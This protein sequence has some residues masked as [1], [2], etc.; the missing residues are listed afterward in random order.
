MHALVRAAVQRRQEQAWEQ[1]W[2]QAGSG[3][4]SGEWSGITLRSSRRMSSP[5]AILLMSAS[6]SVP[7]SVATH[8]REAQAG[9]VAVGEATCIR[10]AR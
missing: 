8:D 2:E 5:A 7:V 4:C 9:V 3:E 6:L 1:A 10:R